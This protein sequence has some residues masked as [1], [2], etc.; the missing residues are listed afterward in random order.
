[1]EP[2]DHRSLGLA[3]RLFHFQDDAAGSVFWHPKGLR[4]W[5]LI[6]EDIRARMSA[7]GF[8]EV[9]SPQLLARRLW[10]ESGHWEKF[11]E[12]MFAFDDGNRHWALKPMSCPG[13]I[14]IFNKFVRSHHDLPLRLCEFGQCHRNEPSGALHGLMR[15]RAF[16]QDDAHVFVAEDDIGAEVARFVALLQAAYADY[17]FP[18][19]LVS[20]GLRPANRAGDDALWDRAETVLR[21]SARANGIDPVDAPGEG[22]F[23]G[24]KLQFSLRDSQGRLW[25][26]GTVQLDYVLPGRLDASFIDRDNRRQRPVLIHHAVLGSLERFIGM[27][28]EQSGG[29]LPFWLAPD[30]VAVL[31]QGVGLEAAA[32]DVA[33]KLRAAGLRA[34]VDDRRE[35][36][37]RKI[38]E[39]RAAGVP[40]ALI[41]GAQ[42]MAAGAWRLRWPNGAQD[43]LPAD[44]ALQRLLSLNAAK[45]PLPQ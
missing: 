8:Q 2:Q 45:S 41:L 9:R 20:L 17:G 33:A 12:D 21:Q 4:L 10:E 6:E 39:Q 38:A 34:L 7:F 1:M 36:L 28:L 5:R 16:V 31:P 14:Q 22:A 24:P 43:L 37:G 3:Q 26:C 11:G 32:A 30:Q 29:M 15:T 44:Q 35:S 19:V 13:H 18:D 40:A 23:Y 27:L 25:Q 42:E